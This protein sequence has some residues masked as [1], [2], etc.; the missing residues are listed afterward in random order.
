MQ[1]RKLELHTKHDYA[2]LLLSVIIPLEKLYTE[3]KA[4]LKIGMTRACYE[5][6]TI[7]MEGFARILWGLVPFW[8]GRNE[9]ADAFIEIYQK[10]IK[11]GTDKKNPEYWGDCH[12]VDQRFVEMAAIAIGILLTP[13]IL[14]DPLGLDTKKH[15]A[16]WLYQINQFESADN[17]WQLCAVLVNVALK[18]VGCQFDRERIQKGL[19][20]IEDFY[21][22]E[23]WYTD[24]ASMQI[25]YHASFSIHYY[26]LIYSAVMEEEDTERC[27]RY[28]ERA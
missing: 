22:G 21:L 19:S 14:W 4:G 20:R 5:T 26:L 7:S 17:N 10:G 2:N 13:D 25:D 28:R 6:Q 3:E 8:K 16:N 9:G 18:K 24:G 11:A 27:E 15:L 23:G 1:D 12:H